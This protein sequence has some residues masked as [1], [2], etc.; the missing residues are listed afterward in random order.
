LR[1]PA[2]RDQAAEVRTAVEPL[3]LDERPYSEAQR[4]RDHMMKMLF[5]MGEVT[6][7]RNSAYYERLAQAFEAVRDILGSKGREERSN[8]STQG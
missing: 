3:A 5:V 6:V 2:L 7:K 4:E 8:V 1:L